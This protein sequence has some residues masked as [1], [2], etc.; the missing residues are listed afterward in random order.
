MESLISVKE[1]CNK[2][3]ISRHLKAGFVE[4]L[5]DEN[6]RTESVFVKEY[7]KFCGKL[8]LYPLVEE[9]AKGWLPSADDTSKPSADM[10]LP[11]NVSHDKAAEASSNHKETHGNAFPQSEKTNAKKEVKNK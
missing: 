9:N 6:E 2:H 3:G 1:F 11:S 7:E 8:V 5:R 10:V 4:H